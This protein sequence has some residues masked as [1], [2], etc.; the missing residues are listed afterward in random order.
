M[1]VQKQRVA[2][3]AVKIS[4]VDEASNDDFKPYNI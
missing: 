1:S 2:E 4:P 3:A